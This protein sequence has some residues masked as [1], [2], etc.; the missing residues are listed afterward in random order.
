MANLYSGSHTF[1]GY[2]TL[3]ELT[4]LTFVADTKYIIQIVTSLP[5]S[6]YVREGS[7]GKGFI[8]DSYQSIEWTYDGVN[9]LYIG[10]TYAKQLTINV[11]G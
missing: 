8:G 11:A 6:F 2:K 7:T 10:N 1:S 4:S 5:H 3:A 9:D